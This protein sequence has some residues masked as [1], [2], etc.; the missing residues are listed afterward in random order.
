M[1]L[2]QRFLHHPVKVYFP[3]VF[4]ERIILKFENI[5]RGQKQCGWGQ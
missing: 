2:Q 4:W 5:G 1:E 3:C